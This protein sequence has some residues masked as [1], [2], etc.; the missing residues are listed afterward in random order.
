MFRRISQDRHCRVVILCASGKN[1]TAGLDLSDHPSL[2]N[3]PTE[4]DFARH[5]FH[6]KKT[7]TDYQDS[8]TAIEECPKPVIAAIHSACVGAGVDMV[9]AADIRLCTSDAWFCIK[10]VDVG[11]AADVGTLQRLPKIV[12]NDSI[13]R[14]LAFTGRRLPGEEAKQLGM[15]SRVY[16][17]KATMDDE[18]LALAVEIASKSPIA[19]QGTKINL[20]YSRDHSV[21]EGLEYVAV[22][23][24]CMLLSRDMTVAGAF[25]LLDFYCDLILHV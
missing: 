24:Q 7:V 6:H 3:P 25:I 21:R 16:A 12:G 23:N 4:G 19:V 2:L 1:F 20:N 17:D 14:E 11:L 18:A 10:E 5:A 13:V 9:S 15:V 8:F 22:W